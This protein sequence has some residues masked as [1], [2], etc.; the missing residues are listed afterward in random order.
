MKHYHLSIIGILVVWSFLSTHCSLLQQ[1]KKP[2]PQHHH[3]QPKELS[4][5]AKEVITTVNHMVNNMFNIIKDPHNS[6][7]VAPNVGKI[8][9]HMTT[10]IFNIAKKSSDRNEQK[11]FQKKLRSLIIDLIA[12]EQAHRVWFAIKVKD[13]VMRTLETEVD[14]L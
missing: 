8:A 3:H 12:E 4:D 11:R 14:E 6:E 7:N 5:N 1:M 13:L 9:E 2:K 10:I